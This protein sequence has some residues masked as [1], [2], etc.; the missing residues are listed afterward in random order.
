MAIVL[1]T[2]RERSQLF[3]NLNLSR[4]KVEECQCPNHAAWALR[5]QVTGAGQLTKEFTAIKWLKSKTSKDEQVSYMKEQ[6]KMCN[7]K[8]DEIQEL[9]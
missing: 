4:E 1:P 6:R 9:L 7:W 5:Q 8:H 2:Q 3:L